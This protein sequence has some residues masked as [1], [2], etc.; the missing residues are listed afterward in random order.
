V[1]SLLTALSL[2][3]NKWV[4]L[5]GYHSILKE[6]KSH[7]V[8][9]QEVFSYNAVSALAA[10]F[11]YTITAFTLRQVSRDLILTTLSRLPYTVQEVQ[12]ER[13]QLVSV[14]ALP[15]LNIPVDFHNQ[16]ASFTSLR[17]HLDSPITPFIIGDFNCVQDPLD[18][19]PGG[20]ICPLAPP[21]TP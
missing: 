4:D 20:P 9:L 10:T 14:G 18:Y 6:T 16:L 1:A 19:N 12:P 11:G 3:I 21:W 13:V 7:L 15:S 8:V 5:G 2:N 17:P